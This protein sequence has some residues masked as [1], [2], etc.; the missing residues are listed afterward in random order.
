[1]LAVER[2]RRRRKQGTE[3]CLLCGW[4][5]ALLRGAE[6]LATSYDRSHKRK[7]NRPQVKKETKTQSNLSP[8]TKT[9]KAAETH[10][11][12][13][14][15]PSVRWPRCET[16]HAEARDQ[17]QTSTVPSAHPT[18]VP[19]QPTLYRPPS[20]VRR[21]PRRTAS[22]A[23]RAAHSAAAQDRREPVPPQQQ[24][25]PK[26]PQGRLYRQR[27]AAAAVA[28]VC[29]AGS[30]ALCRPVAAAAAAVQAG[31]RGAVTAPARRTHRHQQ[32]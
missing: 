24:Q 20:P 8:R 12:R 16:A 27:R 19:G 29:R 26:Q 6:T 1:V 7:H 30:A 21:A 10:T 14:Y 31:R 22:A 3:L 2:K 9:Y 5:Q 23:Q 18:H 13:A 15:R 11:A 28:E 4:Q 25:Q 32:P 17:T